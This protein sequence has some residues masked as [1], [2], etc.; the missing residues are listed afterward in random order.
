MEGNRTQDRSFVS[1]LLSKSWIRFSQSET[2]EPFLLVNFLALAA[3]R[4]FG[5]R[6]SE[7]RIPVLPLIQ[8]PLQA[9]I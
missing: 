6:S 4:V 2:I 1:S 7:Y 3:Q 8:S 5:I 9:V